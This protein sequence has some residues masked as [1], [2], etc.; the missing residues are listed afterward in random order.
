MIKRLSAVL[1]V[2][3][4]SVTVFGFSL[5]LHYC[6]KLLTSVEVNSP[7]KDCGMHAAGKMKCCKEKQ[8]KVKVKDAHQ[9]TPTTA[10]P[11]SFVIDLPAVLFEYQFL[12]DPKFLSARLLS[13]PPP[14]GPHDNTP[15]F[16]KNRNFR[17]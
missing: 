5:D 9:S 1:L 15:T 4:Y 2:M 11:K 3:L 7:S 14:D 16:L 10:S 13:R 12:F 6:G 8:I 17:I